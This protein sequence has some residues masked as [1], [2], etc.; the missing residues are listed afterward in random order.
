MVMTLVLAKS[1]HYNCNIIC[2]MCCENFIN[3]KK[4]ILGICNGF[5]VLL[6][7]GL[8]L[9]NEPEGPPAT[10]TWNDCGRFR[11]S[12]VHLEINNEKCVFLN[13][14]EKLE[15]P[16]AHA[17]GK[18]VARNDQLLDYM[19]V[20]NQLA[21]KYCK[22]TGPNGHVPFPWN[23]NGSVRDVAGVCDDT[24]R[25]LG[26]MPHPERNIDPTHH[27]NWTRRTMKEHGD[28]L[29]IFTN[30]VAYFT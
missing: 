17:E 13:G 26:L 8:L 6:K 22:P 21:I 20:N 23:P 29:A 7:A 2:L 16:I 3:R 27:P 12:W 4:L 19:Q 10:L 30:A 11:D 28:G 14:I 15:L 18:F 9:T 5:Q 1:W 25:V 24:G